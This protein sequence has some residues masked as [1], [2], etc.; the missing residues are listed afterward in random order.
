MLLRR[1]VEKPDEQ[2]V[3]VGELGQEW[4]S[5]CCCCCGSRLVVPGTREHVS[6]GLS[7]RLM[8]SQ[9]RF[10]RLSGVWKAKVRDMS[11][12]MAT[13]TTQREPKALGA[14][15]KV[16]PCGLVL[17]CI[18]A[19]QWRH[20]YSIVDTIALFSLSSTVNYH[21]HP[22]LLVFRDFSHHWHQQPGEEEEEDGTRDV[23]RG[24][25]LRSCS[26]PKS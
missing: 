1:K 23:K 7:H 11:N 12:D 25:W 18:F 24:K 14:I 10:R 21:W 6:K 22:Q 26:T 5:L 16:R 4:V 20:L 2:S 8:P 13:Q 19:P 17:F 9:P 3:S 15:Q